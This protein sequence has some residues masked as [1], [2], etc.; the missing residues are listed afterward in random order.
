MGRIEAIRI[1]R[2]ALAM[3]YRIVHSEHERRY[4]N[5]GHTKQDQ[6]AAD[7]YNIL[8]DWHVELARAEQV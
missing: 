2:L 3:N 1:A 5:I 8:A 7:A 6:Q 4:I